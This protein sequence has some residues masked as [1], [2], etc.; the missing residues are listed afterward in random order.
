MTSPHLSR[1]AA[2]CFRGR[3]GR[4]HS[5]QRSLPPLPE[6]CRAQGRECRFGCEE[7]EEKGVVQDEQATQARRGTVRRQENPS[8]H[9]EVREGGVELQGGSSDF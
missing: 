9:S 8:E 7:F 5:A 6:L 4:P 2:V 1:G 3:Q